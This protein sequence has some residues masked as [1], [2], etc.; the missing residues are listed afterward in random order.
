MRWLRLQ[1]TEWLLH[2][3]ARK[4]CLLVQMCKAVKPADLSTQP[5][6]PASNTHLPHPRWP[7][8][9]ARMHPLAFF[10]LNATFVAFIQ[11][12]VLLGLTTPAYLAWQVRSV[13]VRCMA[14]PDACHSMA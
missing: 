9:R 12:L 1:G 8:L 6:N 11:H 2:L 10:V 3:Q 14:T 4:L 5:S 13:P 7:Y